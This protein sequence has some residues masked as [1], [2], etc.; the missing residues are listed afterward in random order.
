MVNNYYQ[1]HRERKKD[2]GKEAHEKYQKLSKE[3]KNKRQ[4]KAGQRYQ[5]LN[6][7]EKVFSII[8]NLINIFPSN[9][10]RS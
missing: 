4:K 3:E 8:M 9:K 2:T 6:E 1:K 10:K 7:E 5:N